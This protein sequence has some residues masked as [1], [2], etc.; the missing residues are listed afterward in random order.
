[1]TERE[2]GTTLKTFLDAP[3]ETMA[4]AWEHPDITTYVG[5]FTT[6]IHEIIGKEQDLETYM[7]RVHEEARKAGMKT[8]HMLP[9]E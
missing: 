8:N 3:R 2:P 1:M 6:L 9:D 7:E 5:G 4:K